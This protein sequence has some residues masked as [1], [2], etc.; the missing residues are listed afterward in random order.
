MPKFSQS[1]IKKLS[2]CH[3]DIQRVLNEAINHVD[4]T[5]LAGHRTRAEQD[6]A[7]AR[8]NSRVRWPH[9]R[10]NSLPSTAVDV[11][12][13]PIDWSGRE[14][15]VYLAGFIMGTAARMGIRMRWGGD[16]DG[17]L[18][19]LEHSLQDLPHLELAG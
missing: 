8:G 18:D 3:E 12:P 7:Y 15:F 17:D 10:H 16:W 9:S 4:F 13:Y 14:R 1:S 11:A 19:L 6:L 2:S 5:V